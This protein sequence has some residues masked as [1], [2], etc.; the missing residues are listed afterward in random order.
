MTDVRRK[1]SMARLDSQLIDM[2]NE[3]AFLTK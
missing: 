3:A 2:D 1:D